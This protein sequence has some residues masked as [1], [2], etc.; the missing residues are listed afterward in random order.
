[1]NHLSI[2]VVRVQNAYLSSSIQQSIAGMELHDNEADSLLIML[3]SKFSVP[4]IAN[5]LWA[6]SHDPLHFLSMKMHGSNQISCLV[7]SSHMNAIL[8]IT[9]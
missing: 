5:I 9:G 6:P 3:T 2:L 7:V 1:M 4:N 8:Y